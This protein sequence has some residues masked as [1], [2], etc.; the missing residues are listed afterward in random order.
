MQVVARNAQMPPCG[1]I[2]CTAG[3]RDAICPV[4]PARRESLFFLGVQ[5]E[6]V[7]GQK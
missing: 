5:N 4:S 2:D 7:R 6:S 1:K 3:R